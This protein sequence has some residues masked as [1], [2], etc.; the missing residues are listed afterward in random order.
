MRIS[1]KDWLAFV[2]R[3]RREVNACDALQHKARRFIAHL[4]QIGDVSVPRLTRYL[5][6]LPPIPQDRA[7][8]VLPP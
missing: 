3:Q 5:H 2:S 4:P 6:L 1:T 7:T 8:S